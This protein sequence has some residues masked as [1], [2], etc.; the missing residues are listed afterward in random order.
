MHWLILFWT[1][2]QVNLGGSSP[3]FQTRGITCSCR[4]LGFDSRI[5]V[6][7]MLRIMFL[8]L[9]FAFVVWW[10]TSWNYQVFIYFAYIWGVIID[11]L[12]IWKSNN[13]Y[14]LLVKLCWAVF[15]LKVLLHV[16]SKMTSKDTF[17]LYVRIMLLCITVITWEISPHC[18]GYPQ[19]SS[20]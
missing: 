16:L 18:E 6:S 10:C 17:T 9:L 13:M 5:M 19:H 7:K 8:F 14:F 2:S 3:L 15:L 1:I 12:P 11:Y 20:Q 4:S